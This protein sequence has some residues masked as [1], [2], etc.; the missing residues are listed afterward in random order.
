VERRKGDKTV[1]PP[2]S[3]IASLIS[4]GRTVSALFPGQL[5]TS[6]EEKTL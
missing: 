6:S 4:P 3:C 2:K 5:L 1:R